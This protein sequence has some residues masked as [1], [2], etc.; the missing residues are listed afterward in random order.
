M[1]VLIYA[2]TG[3]GVIAIK[4]QNGGNWE[5]NQRRCLPEWEV[6]ELL[7]SGSDLLIAGTRGDGVWLQVDDTWEGRTGGWK[8]PC[9]GR[10]GPGKVHCVTVDP[11][12]PNTIYVGTEPVGMWV[13]HDGGENWTPLEGIEGLP[14]VPDMG[15]PVPSVE[16]HVRDITIDPNNRDVMYAALQVGYL[17]KSTD[18]GS[19][20]RLLNG[21]IDA[22][23][24]TIVIRPDDTN[25][26]YAATGGHGHRAG[27]TMGKALYVSRDAG[28][29]WSPMADEFEQDY[30]VA[31][32][33]HPEN[34]DIL[35]SAVAN[36]PPRWR[37]PS[38]AEARLIG[39]TDGGESWYE[40][41][42]SFDE[43]GPE[44]PGTIAFDPA[45]PDDVYICT[46]KGSLLRSRNG[47]D[48]WERIPVDLA[49]FGGLSERGLSDMRIFHV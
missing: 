30:A 20:W 12:D 43:V 13:T 28:E 34:P 4:E 25:H 19:T 31:L 26:I 42:T 7:V 37:R 3:R 6:T 23:V 49:A 14:S 29:S 48:D 36:G 10:R 21:G 38:G 45:S 9:Y 40:M 27:E 41:E 24:H 39:S 46:H 32:A 1:G 33:M 8:K 15:Y 22:D 44:F 18:R 35:L 5:I 2:G 47:G 17:A 16:P 11:V